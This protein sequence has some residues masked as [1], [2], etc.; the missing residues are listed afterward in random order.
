MSFAAGSAFAQGPMSVDFTK[1]EAATKQAIAAGSDNAAQ[2]LAAEAALKE[3][4]ATLKT[5]SSP[6]V[7]KVTAHLRAAVAASKA[8]NTTEAVAHLN[9]ALGEMKQ[10]VQ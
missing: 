9:G 1:M 3:A 4:K 6:S 10:P 8:G 2:M 7:Q 5:I